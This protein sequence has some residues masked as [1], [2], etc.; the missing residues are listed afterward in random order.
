MDPHP[1]L[2]KQVVKHCGIV[3]PQSP[4]SWIKKCDGGETFAY[5]PSKSGRDSSQTYT[6]EVFECE[7]LFPKRSLTLSQFKYAL[8]KFIRHYTRETREFVIGDER[9]PVDMYIKVWVIVNNLPSV[10]LLSEFSSDFEIDLS[11]LKDD[12]LDKTKIRTEITI[13]EKAN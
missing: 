10:L 2:S 6:V 9:L 13:V 3:T 11:L 12:T 1:I 5:A 4:S 7:W 8:K